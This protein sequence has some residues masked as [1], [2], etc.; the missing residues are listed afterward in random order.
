MLHRRAGDV[1]LRAEVELAE[2]LREQ[3]G[4]RLRH[5]R[6]ENAIAVRSRRFERLAIEVVRIAPK[7]LVEGPFTYSTSS[8]A[9]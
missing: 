3:R 1:R 4:E 8:A 9:L 7:V 2:H 6:L 5:R